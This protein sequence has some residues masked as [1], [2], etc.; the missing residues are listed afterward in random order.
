MQGRHVVN[1]VLLSK[2]TVILLAVSLTIKHKYRPDANPMCRAV[3]R[4][5][6]CGKTVHWIWMPFGVVN[7]VGRGMGVIDGVDIIYRKQ[8]FLEVSVGHLGI[9][10]TNGDFVA[11]LCKSVSIDQYTILSG[12]WGQSRDGCVGW[13]STSQGLEMKFALD[14]LVT[15]YC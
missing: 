4:R 6:D 12:E 2:C 14:S 5:V 15:Q 10:V 13:E 3:S 1:S 8:T 7:V 9:I 11:Q